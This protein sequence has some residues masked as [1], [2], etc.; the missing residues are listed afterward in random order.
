MVY[1]G[2]KNAIA[3]SEDGVEGHSFCVSYIIFI[4]KIKGNAQTSKHK[5]DM[6]SLRVKHGE[7]GEGGLILHTMNIFYPNL[8]LP[9]ELNIL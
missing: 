6:S 8:H 2:I 7:G 4:T 1:L 9:P 5:T 3:G